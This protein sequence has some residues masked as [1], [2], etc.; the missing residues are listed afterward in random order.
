MNDSDDAGLE[1]FLI[2]MDMGQPLSLAFSYGTVAALCQR[3]PDRSEPNDDS[4]A[5]I[6]TRGGQLVLVVAD[7]VGGCPGGFQASAISVRAIAANVRTAPPEADLRPFI[8]DGIEQAHREVLELS[9]GAAT[10]LSVVEIQPES[11]RCYQVGDSMAMLIGQRG[12]MKWKSTPHSPVGFAIESGLLDEATAM[13]HDERHLVSNLIGGHQM[14]IEIG[15]VEPIGKRDSVLV[16]SDG[17]FDNLHLQEIVN[18]GRC[19][20][21]IQRVSAL[22]NLSTERMLN[23]GGAQPGKPD[24][25]TILLYHR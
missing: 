5:V 19:G 9:I 6:Q 8:L 7:G 14:Y 10:T 4:G 23:A 16:G 2:D 12:K 21:L 18:I 24:D 17:L 20:P 25:L 13:Q 1:H 11:M 3:C 22:A 15:P